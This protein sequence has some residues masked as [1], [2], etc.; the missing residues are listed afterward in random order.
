MQCELGYDDGNKARVNNLSSSLRML[1]VN[2]LTD[3][4]FQIN[5]ESVCVCGCCA[6]E[7]HDCKY[8]INTRY[9]Y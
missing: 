8:T 3:T 9:L 2:C 1:T 7:G 6:V 4:W 5:G